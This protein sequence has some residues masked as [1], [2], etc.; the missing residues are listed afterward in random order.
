MRDR[1]PVFKTASPGRE[2]QPA[3]L[4]AVC[5]APGHADGSA[6]HIAA[7]EAIGGIPDEILYDR[8]ALPLASFRAA[9]KLER[10]VSHEGMVSVGGNL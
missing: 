2:L 8:G 7:L 6:R 10:W 9:L 1:V 3:D 4:R 5:P